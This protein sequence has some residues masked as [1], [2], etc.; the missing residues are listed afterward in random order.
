MSA[1]YCPGITTAEELQDP[2]PLG[3]VQLKDQL[4]L[5]QYVRGDLKRA[6]QSA[7]DSFQLA[8]TKFSQDAPIAA[9]CQL[10]LGT[11]LQG[12]L[13]FHANSSSGSVPSHSK[14]VLAHVG[15]AC[16]RFIALLS[17]LTL[18]WERYP[19][20]HVLVLMTGQAHVFAWSCSMSMEACEV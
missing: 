18:I 1:R 8:E 11:V 10:R 7:R 3:L 15:T 6:R 4:A 9:M 5:L 20:L 2:E 14:Q 17:R 16:S 13:C 19:H 12:E